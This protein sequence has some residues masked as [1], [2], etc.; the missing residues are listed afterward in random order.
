[1][2]GIKFLIIDRHEIAALGLLYLIMKNFPEISVVRHSNSGETAMGMITSEHW[3]IVVIDADTAEAH[4]TSI[5]G[6]LSSCNPTASVLVKHNSTAASR[7]GRAAGTDDGNAIYIDYGSEIVCA[8]LRR[9]IDAVPPKVNAQGNECH[10]N[11]TAKTEPQTIV[12]S[13]RESV[14]LACIAQGMTTQEIAKELFVSTNTVTT[15]RQHLLDKFGARNMVDLVIRAIAK[16]LV[17][18]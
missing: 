7:R 10:A 2:D 14:V 12:L 8:M 6:K 4:L 16:G 9:C 3:D 13:P 5:V 15:H 18:V 17:T 11:S 1:M